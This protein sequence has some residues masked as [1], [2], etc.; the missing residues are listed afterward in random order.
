MLLPAGA[1]LF[2]CRALLVVRIVAWA[3]RSDR[4]SVGLW[5]VLGAGV[6][7]VLLPVL[8]DRLYVHT[9][10]WVDSRLFIAQL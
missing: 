1:A 8:E 9:L 4:V 7:E 10:R 2:R 3:F 5:R 6:R